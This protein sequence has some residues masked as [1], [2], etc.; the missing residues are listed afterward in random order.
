[1]DQRRNMAD[2]RRKYLDD[3]ETIRGLMTRYEERSLVRPW[4]FGAWG[5]LVIIGTIAS[6]HMSRSE[7]GATRIV[8]LVWLP[9]LI[10]GGMLE[11][12]GWFLQNRQTGQAIFTR[13]MNRLVATYGGIVAIVAIMALELVPSGLSVAVV[14]AL[15]AL[16]L[17]AYAQMT[18][19]SLYIE[20][21]TLVAAAI[22]AAIWLSDSFGFVS[23]AGVV[24]GVL[25][26]VTGIH[27]RIQ[28]R[29]VAA[30]AAD[31]GEDG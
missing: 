10:V 3:L 1:M 12:L 24:V 16:P 28:E 27:T 9:V 17:L 11:G 18:F 8:L 20:A 4:V 23:L 25:Y 14:L 29:R 15:G 13:R 7:V 2:D 19:S 6:M 22:G 5:A 31:S 26:L 30:G 21:F